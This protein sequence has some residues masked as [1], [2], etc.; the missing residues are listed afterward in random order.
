LS[1]LSETQRVWVQRVIRLAGSVGI[2][3]DR[4]E[5]LKF[6]RQVVH[7]SQSH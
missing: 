7:A 5:Q 2:G 3:A 6:L 1:G 4:Q